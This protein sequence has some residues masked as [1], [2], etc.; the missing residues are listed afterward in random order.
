[1][2]LQFKIEGLDEVKKLLDPART[3]QAAT[4]RSLNE[5]ARKCR[6]AAIDSIT[7]KFNIKKGDLSQTSTGHSRI[8]VFPAVRGSNQ[9]T[10]EFS[11]RPIS[12]AYFGARQISRSSAGV[13]VTNRNGSKMQKRAKGATGVTV[14]IVRGKRTVLGSSFVAKVVAGKT[15]GFHTGV[16]NRLT[17]ARLPIAEKRLITVASMFEQPAPT[18]AVQEV[19]QRDFEEIFIRNLKWY[20]S[21]R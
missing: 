10:I 18:K 15:A 17:K 1:M 4:P 16:F 19:V 21:T 8:K 6:T 20:A 3:I 13:R 9:A 5:V 12:L 2:N 11:G 14:E 7:Q